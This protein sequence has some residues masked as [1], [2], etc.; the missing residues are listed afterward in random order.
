MFVDFMD[1][2]RR[3]ADLR[4]SSMLLR[5][6][7]QLLA[8]FLVLYTISPAAAQDKTMNVGIGYQALKFDASSFPLGLNTD[9]VAGVTEHLAV[10][11]E[12]GWA[13]DSTHQFGLRDVTTGLHVG[14]GGRWLISRKR[15]FTPFGQILVGLEHDRTAIEK[16]GSDSA[17]TFLVQPGGGIIVRVNSR[18]DVFGQVDLH[19]VF[20][21]DDHP[22]AA[23]FLIGLRYNI[24]Q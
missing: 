10:V 8:F 7:S 21:E 14:G 12:F 4:I 16:F 20:Q 18:Q 19:R 17:S 24:R 3:H 11:G 2:R 23:R 22:T 5:T 9:F 15:R 6:P 1:S 13:R